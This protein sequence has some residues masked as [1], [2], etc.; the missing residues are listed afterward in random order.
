MLSMIQFFHPLISIR[1]YKPCCFSWCLRCRASVPTLHHLLPLPWA[2]LHPP[3]WCHHCRY[4]MGWHLQPQ[5]PWNPKQ[6]ELR[7]CRVGSWRV[8]WE[9]KVGVAEIGMKFV[10]FLKEF[11]HKHVGWIFFVKFRTGIRPGK[12]RHSSWFTIWGEA[13]KID[14]SSSMPKHL[15]LIE[16]GSPRHNFNDWIKPQTLPLILLYTMAESYIS[17]DG[18]RTR[19]K[20]FRSF[21]CDLTNVA[22]KMLPVDFSYE[23]MW[24]QPLLHGWLPLQHRWHGFWIQWRGRWW[25]RWHQWTHCNSARRYFPHGF[26]RF[27]SLISL[28]N[29]LE[30]VQEIIWFVLVWSVADV[31]CFIRRCLW[32]LDC[33]W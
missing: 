29:Y 14:C 33:I 2:L 21:L 9:A 23:G 6:G 12:M 18:T 27:S 20:N 26:C 5:H 3:W 31:W 22:W 4:L 28:S 16:K 7:I 24:P 25:I 1:C 17:P 30:L 10:F 11:L 19:C 13:S 8:L 15:S 32:T